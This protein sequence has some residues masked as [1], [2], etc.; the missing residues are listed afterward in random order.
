M[1]EFDRLIDVMATLRSEK[2]CP[3]DREQDHRTLVPYLLEEAYE[4]V[5]AIDEEN[6]DA[7][8]EELGDLLLQIVF[9]AQVAR[10]AG[11]FT[12]EQ[13]IDGIVNKLLRRHPHVFSNAVVE[14]AGDVVRQW[15]EIKKGEKNHRGGKKAGLSHKLPALQMA[16]HVQE[17]MSKKGFEG[18]SLEQ[19]IRHAYDAL[20]EIKQDPSGNGKNQI[21]SLLF[22]A[23]NIARCMKVNPE[24]ALRKSSKEEESLSR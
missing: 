10:E 22:H 9:H 16:E 6:R 8:C 14:N 11:E 7:L 24:L 19:S 4:I 15:N 5:D 18:L 20:D 1:N 12:M 21:G 3:W 17:H 23:V 2:G 13:V